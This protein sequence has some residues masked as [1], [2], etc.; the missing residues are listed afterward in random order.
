MNI[1]FYIIFYFIFRLSNTKIK[2]N[3]KLS[4]KSIL[5]FPLYAWYLYSS[6]HP[7][8]HISNRFLNCFYTSC[9][10]FFMHMWGNAYSE[11][12]STERVKIDYLTNDPGMMGSSLKKIKFDPPCTS[13]TIINSR[14][15]KYLY[16]KQEAFSILD[17][18]LF[19]WWKG[20]CLTMN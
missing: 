2:L 12:S 8:P 16:V 9:H 15:I 17:E 19:F 7:S 6:S 20:F 3:E 5:S 18:N 4:E 1:N 10:S 14:C 13:C 11:T